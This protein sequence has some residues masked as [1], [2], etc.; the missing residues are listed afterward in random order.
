MDTVT[1]CY[2]A[3]LLSSCFN[4]FQQQNWEYTE[5]QL[6]THYALIPVCLTLPLCRGAMSVKPHEMLRKMIGK[7]GKTADKRESSTAGFN[8]PNLHQCITNT[9]VQQKLI[10]RLRVQTPEGWF[11]DL[12]ISKGI[13]YLITYITVFLSGVLKPRLLQGVFPVLI[14]PWDIRG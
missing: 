7:T 5:E 6:Q 10:Q 11:T 3:V 2:L 13:L 1:V 14:V 12:R 9:V 8:K 4:L